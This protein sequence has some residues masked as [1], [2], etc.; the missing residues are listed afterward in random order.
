MFSRRRARWY[1]ILLI[2]TFMVAIFLPGLDMLVGFDKTP[3]AGLTAPPPKITGLRSLASLPGQFK[4]YFN[5]N[6]GLRP[7]LIHVNGVYKTKMLGLSSSNKVLL[8]KDGWLFYRDEHTLDDYRNLY[9][10]TDDE[11]TYWT[12]LYAKRQ[13]FCQQRGITYLAIVPPNKASIYPEYLPDGW[14]PLNQPKRL[15]QLKTSMETNHPEVTFL[16]VREQLMARKNDA[17]LYFPTDTHWNEVGA[18]VGY[19]Q[20]MLALKETHPEIQVPEWGDMQIERR[21]SDGGDLARMLGTK[22]ITPDPLVYP[23]IQ[24]AREVTRVK[25]GSKLTV[26]VKDILRGEEGLVTHCADGELESAV[27]IHDS[28]GQAMIPLIARH[29][30]RAVFIWTHDFQPELIEKEKPTVVIQEMAERITLNITPEI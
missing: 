12:N 16:D 20:V 27:V 9:P 6:F 1:H 29:F 30:K 19:R 4:W 10:F 7:F 2:A 5:E 25:D 21:D 23:V 17:L 24:P 13:D 3:V 14:A 26:V 11:L 28:F 8:G 22:F 15:D 18:F